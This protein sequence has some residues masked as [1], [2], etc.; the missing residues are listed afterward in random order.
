MQ[1]ERI[2]RVPKPLEPGELDSLRCEIEAELA[3]QLCASSGVAE[4]TSAQLE[5]VAAEAVARAEAEAQRLKAAAAAAEAEA[6]HYERR[7]REV[8][9]K[10]AA[11]AQASHVMAAQKAELV[12]SASWS[13]QCNNAT[14]HQ[15]NVTMPHIISPM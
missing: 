5:A 10:V 14:H 9:A 15:P 4:L 6:A 11:A 7:Q 1:Q 2:V 3:A 12:V 8:A 13:V